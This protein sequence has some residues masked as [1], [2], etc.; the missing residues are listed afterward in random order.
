MDLDAKLD[1]SGF[2]QKKIS[3]RVVFFEKVS[4]R[5]NDD[6]LLN[7]MYNLDQVANIF[8]MEVSK[9][10]LTTARDKLAVVVNLLFGVERYKL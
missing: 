10:Y 4:V 9:Q 3:K 5:I 1:Q 6:M 7:P 2:Q 8:S